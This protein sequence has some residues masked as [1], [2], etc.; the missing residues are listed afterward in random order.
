MD[1][2]F[3]NIG[4]IISEVITEFMLQKKE[5]YNFGDNDVVFGE[6][7]EIYE[8]YFKENLVAFIILVHCLKTDEEIEDNYFYEI[9]FGKLTN[10]ENVKFKK[11]LKQFLQNE[12]KEDL[13]IFAVVKNTNEDDRDKVFNILEENGFITTE[14]PSER[15]FIPN[16][17]YQ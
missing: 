1:F 12:Y 15:I 11:I 4:H 5:S 2:K 17:N 6:A 13:K 9:I 10:D 16:N 7:Y 8:C 3:K 14:N